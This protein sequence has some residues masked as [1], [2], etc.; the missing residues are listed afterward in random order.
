[1]GARQLRSVGILARCDRF[2][3]GVAQKALRSSR[4]G[5][6]G[7]EYARFSMNSLNG[8]K[9]N[10]F[11]A[12]N[13]SGRASGNGFSDLPDAETALMKQIACSVNKS[14]G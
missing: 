13:D 11:N 2:P 9:V 12:P 14:R 1:M 10:A 3:N 8:A 7:K 6:I 5:R 4:V